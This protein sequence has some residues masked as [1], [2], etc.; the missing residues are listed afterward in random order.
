M[1][2]YYY[3][4]AL[5]AMLLSQT[6]DVTAQEH[7]CKVEFN[8]GEGMMMVTR[9]SDNGKYISGIEY[10]GEG[11]IWNSE[12]GDILRMPV[13][14]D[15][16]VKDPTTFAWDVTDKG[17]VVGSYV[18]MPGTFANGEWEF[19]DMPGKLGDATSVTPDGKIITGWVKDDMK[20]ACM[21]KEGKLIIL[22]APKNDNT[23]RPIQYSSAEKVSADGSVITG[24]IRSY[25]GNYLLGMIWQAPEYEPVMLFA[26][27]LET[28]GGRWPSYTI[29]EVSPNGKWLT[30]MYGVRVSSEEVMPYVFRYNLETKELDLINDV[31]IDPGIGDGGPTAI[32]NNGT[33]YSTTIPTGGNPWARTAYVSRV[34]KSS[35]SLENLLKE[36][37][38]NSELGDK[39]AFSGGIS[40]VTPAGNIL[41]GHGASMDEQLNFD[42]FAYM[43]LLDGTTGISETGTGASLDCFAQGNTLHLTGEPVSVEIVN[44][45]GAVVYNSNVQG[46]S[47]SVAGLPAGVYAVKLFD[48]KNVKVQ[49]IALTAR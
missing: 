35:I 40:G 13:G 26:D 7:S 49:K 8:E 21:W 6:Q 2:K 17:V 27:S 1:R 18:D 39:L 25:F 16:T 34:G 29:N 14:S 9:I 48:G 3:L 42:Y 31:E 44:M 15:V 32:D 38:N 11:Y 10:P 46:S 43:L 12:K 33:V 37:Y 22:N 4:M 5:G 36:E 45:A 28:S 41:V 20:R 24:S 30:G 19:L 47:V 23:G